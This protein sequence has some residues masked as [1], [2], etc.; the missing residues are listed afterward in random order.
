MEMGKVG[1]ELE[2]EA[3]MG[4][5]RETVRCHQCLIFWNHVAG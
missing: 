4:Q 5:D 1:L 2:L 3:Q